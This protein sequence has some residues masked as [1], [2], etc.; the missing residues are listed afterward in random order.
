MVNCLQIFSKEECVK[1]ISV[2]FSVPLCRQMYRHQFIPWSLRGHISLTFPSHKFLFL[3]PHLGH[4]IFILLIHL[5]LNC[6]KKKKIPIY[7]LGLVLPQQFK[8]CSPTFSSN[9]L[10]S[11]SLQRTIIT[12]SASFCAYF[13][14]LRQ[15]LP[16]VRTLLP[17]NLVATPYNVEF[18]HLRQPYCFISLHYLTYMVTY[19]YHSFSSPYIP[20]LI[21]FYVDFDFALKS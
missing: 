8:V 5:S 2:Q 16:Y 18:D 13:L 4:P 9:L 20:L 10:C 21:I 14:S 17:T 15:W 12:Y 7:L 19:I 1:V 3:F 11:A 6:L